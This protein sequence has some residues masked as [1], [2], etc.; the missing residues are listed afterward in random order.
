MPH[1]TIPALHPTISA[2]LLIGDWDQIKPLLSSSNLKEQIE[3]ANKLKELALSKLQFL[4]PRGKV[5]LAAESQFEAEQE[6]FLKNLFTTISPTVKPKIAFALGELGGQSAAETLAEFLT[7]AIEK[8]EK[9]NQEEQEEFDK[10]LDAGV[11]AL[12]NIGGM[13]AVK[14]LA[15]LAANSDL[16]INI[17]RTALVNLEELGAGGWDDFTDQPSPPPRKYKKAEE[18]TDPKMREDWSILDK[19]ISENSDR[20][21]KLK[22]EA[23]IAYLERAYLERAVNKPNI[24]LENIAYHRDSKDTL[25]KAK[26]SVKIEC[27]VEGHITLLEVEADSEGNGPINAVCKAIDKI[28]KDNLDL[29][30]SLTAFS[31]NFEKGEAEQAGSDANAEVTVRLCK[32]APKDRRFS[33]TAKDEDTVWAA[34]KAYI[35]AINEALDHTHSPI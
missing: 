14:T 8:P 24:K 35:A 22:A 1:P 34:A 23:A 4:G 29:V 20:K 28:V 26:I 21:L 11:D 18:L 12:M 5:Y 19:I 15:N 13:T 2:Q 9:S 25:A 16:P 31:I 6:A 33:K 10:L 30:Y 27:F 17:R 3:G 7:L 32:D